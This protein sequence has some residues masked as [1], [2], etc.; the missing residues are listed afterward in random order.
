[1]TVIGLHGI[2]FKEDRLKDSGRLRV[3]NNKTI[4]L[5]LYQTD[6]KSLLR[7]MPGSPILTLNWEKV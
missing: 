7:H 6:Q 3:D 1:M 5:G 2:T 4:M